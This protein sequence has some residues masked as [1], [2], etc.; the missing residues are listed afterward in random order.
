M[1]NDKSMKKSIATGNKDIFNLISLIGIQAA[2]AILPLIVFP[3]LLTSV[4]SKLYSKIALTE[5]IGVIILTAVI[6]SFDIDGVTRISKLKI[7]TD[8]DNIS[9]IFSEIFLSRL[10]V[11]LF[12]R[13]WFFLVVLFSIRQ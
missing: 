8:I 11:F 7:K 2:N 12:A 6:Y 10:L 13:H 1:P 5:A 3:H 9:I 4:G